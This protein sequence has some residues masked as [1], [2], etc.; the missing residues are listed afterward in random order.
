V[1]I[2]LIVD[3]FKPNK[4]SAAVQMND[5]A[6]EFKDQG[7]EVTLLVPSPIIKKEYVLEVNDGLSV[8]YLKAPVYK[9]I[10]NI[11]RIIGE[12]LMPYAMLINFKKTPISKVKWDLLVWYS[13]SIFHEPLV[14]FIKTGSRCKSYLILRDIFPK[15]ALDLGLINKGIK[16]YI[17]NKVAEKQYLIADKIGVQSKGNLRIF[18]SNKNI[19]QK[20]EVLQNWLA[21]NELHGCT[22]DISKT[23]LCGRMIYIY[24]GNMGVA[25]NTNLFI[26][27]AYKL[28]DN[29]EIGFLFIGRG[30]DF[31]RYKNCEKIIKLKNLLFYNEIDPSGINQLL[32]QCSVGLISLDYRHK[33]HNIPGK[34]LHYMQNGL[35]VLANISKSM[36]LAYIIRKENL[37]LVNTKPTIDE[38]VF[39]ILKIKK[40]IFLD[41]NIKD[42]CKLHYFNN[43]RPEL[44]VKQIL[45]SIN[46]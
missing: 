23:K 5:L 29:D 26:E 18:S 45:S 25:Q 2:I 8:L 38:L 27:A 15:W 42:R 43:F 14:K 12:V 10:G 24:A 32:G 31:D 17:L 28:R 7:H 16:Y 11:S 4:N 40:I 22:V 1:K 9:N 3:T 37:G 41:K 36:D 44:A 39:N 20:V 35:P 33:T 46:Q 6:C 30:S 21:V 34:F 19:K 13:P